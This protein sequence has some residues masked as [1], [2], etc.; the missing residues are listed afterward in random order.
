MTGHELS[1]SHLQLPLLLRNDLY[2]NRN[3][4]IW[5]TS[6]DHTSDNN[7]NQLILPP[8]FHFS[9][10]ISMIVAM[11][12]HFLSLAGLIVLL[13]LLLLLF[14]GG[15]HIT[16]LN[17]VK[18]RQVT[19]NKVLFRIVFLFSWLYKRLMAT[20]WWLVSSSYFKDILLHSLSS[21]LLLDSAPIFWVSYIH[22][23]CLYRWRHFYFSPWLTDAG[24]QHFT[25]AVVLNWSNWSLVNH[26][27]D[28]FVYYCN[29]WGATLTTLFLQQ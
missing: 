7:N 10:I 21:H 5:I 27:A 19:K 25:A 24:Q 14:M 8:F 15:W 3:S 4:W 9:L 26:V 13:L 20:L 22:F 18:Y 11:Q 2:R 28:W 16:P 6:S 23:V 1:L 12:Q 17:W 29:C